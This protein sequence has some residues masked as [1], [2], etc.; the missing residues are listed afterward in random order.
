L[1]GKIGAKNPTMY[2]SFFEERRIF[3]IIT[4]QK[5][6]LTPLREVA[7]GFWARALGR[8]FCS[9][10]HAE[11][12]LWAYAGTTIICYTALSSEAS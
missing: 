8:T 5:K 7:T 6:I 12:K 10:A 4:P 11:R 2:R 9:L 1:L 3:P